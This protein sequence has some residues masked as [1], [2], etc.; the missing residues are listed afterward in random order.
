MNEL[1]SVFFSAAT[2]AFVAGLLVKVFIERSINN[3]FDKRITDYKNQIFKN[4]VIFNEKIKAIKALNK[5]YY[6]TLPKRR[7][8]DE[9]W[10]SALNK[11][12]F[13]SASIEKNLELFL[14]EFDHFIT[15]EISEKIKTANSIATELRIEL[16]GQTLGK[17][18]YKRPD[19]LFNYIQE[20]RNL[21]I[22][23]LEAEAKIKK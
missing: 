23:E 11:I 7:Y 3:I 5:I 9:D 17:N 16:D 14:T 12:A 1:I 8:E 19:E 4:Q 13:N 18:E 20:A 22:N 6:H 21:L 15:R 10:E 2:G